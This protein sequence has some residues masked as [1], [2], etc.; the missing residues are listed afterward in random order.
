MDLVLYSMNN[1]ISLKSQKLKFYANLP[2]RELIAS[3]DLKFKCYARISKIFEY[4]RFL[5]SNSRKIKYNLTPEIFRNCFLFV[6]KLE[7]HSKY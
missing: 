1:S 6:V 5:L 2:Q 4:K 3:K 7:I